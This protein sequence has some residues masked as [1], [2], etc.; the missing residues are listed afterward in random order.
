MASTLN[1]RH[2]MMP[3]TWSNPSN[4]KYHRSCRLHAAIRGAH[5][6]MAPPSLL[7]S[8]DQSFGGVRAARISST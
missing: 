5:S 4:R 7:T 3:G 6:Y 8:A 1:H 2:N